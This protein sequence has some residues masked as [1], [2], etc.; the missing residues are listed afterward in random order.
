MTKKSIDNLET[1]ETSHILGVDFGAAKIGLALA[2]RETKIAFTYTTLPNNK[3]FLEKLA[4]IIKKESV[5]LIIIGISSFVNS[6]G[7]MMISN[8]I[9]VTLSCM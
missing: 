4:E 7:V 9:I 2:E 8:K 5:D 6:P 3:D 1:S